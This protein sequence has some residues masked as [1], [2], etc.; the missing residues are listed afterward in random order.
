M[1]PLKLAGEA[2]A[3]DDSGAPTAKADASG[4][5]LPAEQRSAATTNFD[6]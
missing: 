6:V 3:S 5:S 4:A 2:R 1:H